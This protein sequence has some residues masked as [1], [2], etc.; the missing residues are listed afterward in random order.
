MRGARALGVALVG[1]VGGV[2][3]GQGPKPPAYPPLNLG[4]ARL[5]ATA[6]GLGGPATAVAYSAE[7]KLLLAGCERGG[8]R[9][10]AEEEGK[11]PLA[12]KGEALKGHDGAVTA[13]AAAGGT[14]ASGGVD[15]KV[16]LWA[17][18]GGKPAHKLDTK[19]IVRAV[20]VAPDGKRVAGAG[21]DGK[22]RLWDSGGK[23]LRELSGPKDWLL[24]VAFSPDGK[25]VGAGGQDGRL[26][27]WDA[28]SGKKVFDVPVAAAAPPGAPPAPAN[29]VSA[30]AF[31]P[32]GKQVAVGGSDA[33]VYLLSSGDGKLV[34][35]LPG[36][37]GA[38]T[39]LAFHP[40]GSPLASASADG[41][42]RLWDPASG[43]ALKALAG[44]TAWVQGAVFVGRGTRLATAGADRTV[45]AWELTNAP[46]KKK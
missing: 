24:A 10:W 26:W 12:G 20:A 9:A 40:G 43:G 38:V 11:A 5:G 27:V 44:H 22:V 28:D 3:G 33:K 36:H 41:S 32:D 18:P 7:K 16:I 35:Q 15:G 17:L 39:A 25:R 30:V 19:T 46:V 6:S 13:V 42:V 2:A 4:A 37:T 45:R 34:R 31:S 21:D 8:V 1:L 29:V 23:A 14:V